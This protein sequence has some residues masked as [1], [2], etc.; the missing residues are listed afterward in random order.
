MK[1][2]EGGMTSRGLELEAGKHAGACDGGKSGQMGWK[3]YP[4]AEGERRMEARG[5]SCGRSELLAV[6]V[7]VHI[8]ADMRFD[9]F[10]QIRKLKRDD[11]GEDSAQSS[12]IELNMSSSESEEESRREGG[13]MGRG[14]EMMTPAR[15][16]PLEHGGPTG[17]VRAG[18]GSESSFKGR[19]DHEGNFSS[20]ARS[21]FRLARCE[22]KAGWDLPRS[23]RLRPWKAG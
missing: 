10:P 21:E 16:H 8:T 3:D 20:S 15:S 9:E 5:A 7:A 18:E 6:G 4:M 13:R 11:G 12:H 1:D 19:C 17:D 14:G 2:D 23:S 22:A